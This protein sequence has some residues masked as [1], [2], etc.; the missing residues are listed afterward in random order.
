MVLFLVFF[1]P[2]LFVREKQKKRKTYSTRELISGAFRQIRETFR[3]IKKNRPLFIFIIG[4]IFVS[5]VASVLIIYMTPLV[6]DGLVN[7]I[8]VMIL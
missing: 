3:D 8:R 6:T 1:I 5:D 2:F 4:Y 7:L